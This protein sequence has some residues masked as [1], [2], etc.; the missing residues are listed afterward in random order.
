MSETLFEKLW[1]S[2]VVRTF[3]GRAIVRGTIS[4]CFHLFN[5]RLAQLDAVAANEDIP[6]TFDQR[7]TVP[8]ALAAE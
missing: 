6:G 3:G 7:S 5:D 4:A 1:K 2:H 8:I